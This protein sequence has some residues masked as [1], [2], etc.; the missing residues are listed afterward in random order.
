MGWGEWG[1]NGEKNRRE[2]PIRKDRESGIE[3]GNE[4]SKRQRGASACGEVDAGKQ[5]IGDVVKGKW[6]KRGRRV[7]GNRGRLGGG[8]EAGRG[9]GR[10]R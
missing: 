5:L 10:V 1:E 2:G 4:S 6:A 9:K 8:G 3:K 7:V